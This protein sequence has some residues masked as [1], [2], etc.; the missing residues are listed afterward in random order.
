MRADAL[1]NREALV[2]VAVTLLSRSDAD[3]SLESIAHEAGVGIGTLYRHFPTREALVATAYG[4][5]IEQLCGA[6]DGLLATFPPEVALREWMQWFVDYVA[7]KRELPATLQSVVDVGA[8]PFP[9]LRSRIVGALGSLMAA[10]VSA[11]TIRD[12]LQ[13]DD[14]LRALRGIWMLPDGAERSEQARRLLNL[15]MDGLRTGATG[16]T[17]SGSGP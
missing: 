15:L 9:R 5:E 8:A 11:G 14:T 1:R 12:D 4:N 17:P 7:A 16:S 2:A 10:G 3:V 13:A 6:A